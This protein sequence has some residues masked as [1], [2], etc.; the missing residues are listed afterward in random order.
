MKVRSL[1]AALSLM[2]AG[3]YG[4]AQQS[5]WADAGDAVA[6]MV[7]D[8]ERKWAES[9][10]DHNRIGETI[11]ADDFY[12]TAPDGSR[13]ERAKEIEGD[14][15]RKGR[16]CKLDGARVRFFGDDLA[17]VYGSERATIPDHEG[18]DA[19][20]CLVWSDTWLKR[21]GKWQVIS[22]QDTAVACQ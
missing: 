22:A 14:S 9:S 3:S 19:L 16:D 6:K 1:A 10:C 12:G 18:K 20:R 4:F 21:N 15:S 7:I 17:M 8:S 2:F 5:H 13:Y 11:L